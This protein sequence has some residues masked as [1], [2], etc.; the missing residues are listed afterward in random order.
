M[1]DHVKRKLLP[2]LFHMPPG[3]EDRAEKVELA[4]RMITG[5]CGRT[6]YDMRYR[7]IADPEDENFWAHWPPELGDEGARQAAIAIAAGRRTRD[8]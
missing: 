6:Q 2:S 1:A 5:R 7:Q 3:D 4:H 8:L